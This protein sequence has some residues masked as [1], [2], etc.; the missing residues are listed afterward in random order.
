MHQHIGAQNG[1]VVDGYLA[2]QFCAVS[3]DDSITHDG[4]VSHMHT[5]HQQV[6]IADDSSSLG[7]CAPIDGNILTYLVVITNLCS[8]LFASELK[9]LWNGTNDCAWEEYVPITNTGAV[10]YR[11]AIHQYVIVAYDNTFIYIA[12]RAYLAILTNNGI[13]VNVC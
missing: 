9:V 12:E 1:I 7:G 2:C 6:I 13:W 4:V 8:T 5:F 11:H 3:D 10:E